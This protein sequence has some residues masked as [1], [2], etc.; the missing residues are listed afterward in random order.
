MSESVNTR[1]VPNCL[2]LQPGA[3]SYEVNVYHC[4]VC[5]ATINGTERAVQHD[6]CHL[7]PKCPGCASSR[8]RPTL[9][10]NYGRV[11]VCLVCG[12]VFSTGGGE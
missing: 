5:G 2:E 3:G 12:T 8:A 7:A 6:F 1:G 9:G 11:D 4:M 10:T